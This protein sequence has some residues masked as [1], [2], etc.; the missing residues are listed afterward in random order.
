MVCILNVLHIAF[1]VGVTETF[2]LKSFLLCIII[3]SSLSIVFS[4]FQFRQNRHDSFL[5]GSLEPLIMNN[6]LYIQNKRQHSKGILSTPPSLLWLQTKLRCC[7]Q[8][9]KHMPAA[10]QERWHQPGLH[11]ITHPHTQFAHLPCNTC[12]TIHTA[13]C[14][15]VTQ[16]ANIIQLL[17]SIFSSMIY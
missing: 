11:H 13:Y 9:L 1:C 17:Y 7:C 6:C 12:L 15:D 14:T 3:I 16:D 10:V 8:S 5:Y 4:S 2:S